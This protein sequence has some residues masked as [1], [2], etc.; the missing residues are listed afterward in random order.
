MLWYVAG[1]SLVLMV[2]GGCNAILGVDHFAVDEDSGVTDAEIVEKDAA[3]DGPPA[4]DASSDAPIDGDGDRDSDG[5]DVLDPV[6]NC[7]GVPNKDQ[8]DHDGDS[9]GDVCDGCPHLMGVAAD[10]DGDKVDDLCDPRPDTP[11]DSI[12][13]FDGFY[14]DGNALPDGWTAATGEANDWQVRNGEL[15]PIIGD[16]VKFAYWS[17]RGL[18]HQVIDTRVTVRQLA[19]EALQ[20][21]ILIVGGYDGNGA[22]PFWLCG[23]VDDMDNDPP[24]FRLHEVNSSGIGVGTARNS[25]P[26]S[27]PLSSITAA[28]VRLELSNEAGPKVTERCVLSNNPAATTLTDSDDVDASGFVGIRTRGVQ[29]GFDYVVIYDRIN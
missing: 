21:S 11:G 14:E 5:D 28:R 24:V 9:R 16:G 19:T 27:F 3:Q 17:V 1:S 2:L 7:V 12:M 26:L 29:T 22:G 25:G 8:R 23:F 18:T 4:S 10:R 6:D 15:R 13:H 20:R